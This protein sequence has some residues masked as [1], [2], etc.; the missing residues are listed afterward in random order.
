MPVF[1]EEVEKDPL[2]RMVVD[3]IL[4][5]LDTESWTL[6]QRKVSIHYLWIAWRS[7][8]HPFL[9]K[10]IEML[11][12]FEIGCRSRKMEGGSR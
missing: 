8:L 9:C 4:V 10:V 12:N 1:C 2:L 11:L 5:E 6:R 3:D 7:G